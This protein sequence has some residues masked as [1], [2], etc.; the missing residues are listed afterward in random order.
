MK[1]NDKQFKDWI[2]RR[3]VYLTN[4]RLF[5]DNNQNNI[6]GGSSIG[7]LIIHLNTQG[8]Y[9]GTEFIGSLG[10]FGRR[11]KFLFLFLIYQKFYKYGII[12]T[13]MDIEIPFNGVVPKGEIGINPALPDLTYKVFRGKHISDHSVLG[14]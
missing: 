9:W 4:A 3:L 2:T 11:S 8:R 13:H 6:E 12:G 5:N 7:I 10:N 14:M 1:F